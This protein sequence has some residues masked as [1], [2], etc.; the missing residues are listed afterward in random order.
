MY[1]FMQLGL[2]RWGLLVGAWVLGISRKSVAK[3]E[4]R[5]LNTNGR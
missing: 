2:G 4:T 3:P 1:D 5:V